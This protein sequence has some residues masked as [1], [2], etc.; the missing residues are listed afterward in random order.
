MKQTEKQRAK[1]LHDLWIMDDHGVRPTKPTKPVEHNS[2]PSTTKLASSTSKT[3]EQSTT[4]KASTAAKPVKGPAVKHSSTAQAV[5]VSNIMVD[6]RTR[7]PPDDSSWQELLQDNQVR[8][9][10]GP[11][12]PTPHKA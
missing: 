3:V 1:V 8:E 11:I 10:F 4:V 2:K 6:T 7:K 9:N 5:D 12:S